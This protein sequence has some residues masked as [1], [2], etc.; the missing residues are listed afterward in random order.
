MSHSPNSVQIPIE[1]RLSLLR[2]L[3]SFETLAPEVLVDIAENLGVEA[4]DQ[5]VDV[6]H[7]GWFGDRMYL[8]ERGVVNV[9]VV[10]ATGS[11][12]LG[13]LGE[14][15]MFGEIALLN[16]GRQRTATVTTECPLVTLTLDVAHFQ[17][18]AVIYPEVRLDLACAAEELM[19]RR[20]E[21]L[22][23][24]KA[25]KMDGLGKSPLTF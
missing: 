9:S 18:L 15:E 13:T 16:E 7:E 6:V 11:V 24:A 3:P 1:R 4:F 23:Q 2:S 21:A 20:F 8:I 17:R 12:P 5:G 10:G 19:Q 22:M 25:Q 14:G